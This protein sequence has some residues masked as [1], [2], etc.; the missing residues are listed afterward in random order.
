MNTA[1]LTYADTLGKHNI[2]LPDDLI[3]DLEVP[4][5]CGNQRQGDVGIFVRGKVG[6]AERASFTPVPPAGLP[7]V[8]GTNTHILDAYLGEVSWSPIVARA[9]DVAIGILDVP[10]GA[11]AYLTHTDEHTTNGIGPGTYRVTG[12]R[13]LADEI[14]RVAD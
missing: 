8:K 5:L 13:E 2:Q 7:I 4:V 12:K 3:A 14:R 10:E 1:T 11:V 9:G 6:K